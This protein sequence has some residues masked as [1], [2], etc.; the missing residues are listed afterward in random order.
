MIANDKVKSIRLLGRRWFQKTFG[1]TYHTCEIWIN[2]ELIHT[3]PYAYGYGSQYRQSAEA[4]LDENGY[5]RELE[6]YSNSLNEPLWHYCERKNIVLTDQVID[7]QRKK[8]L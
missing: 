2:D 1:N 8:D 6:H 7:V 4:W 5:L 3:C